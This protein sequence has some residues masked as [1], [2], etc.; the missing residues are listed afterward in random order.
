MKA[1]AQDFGWSAVAAW[2]AVTT[3]GWVAGVIPMVLGINHIWDGNRGDVILMDEQIAGLTTYC[4]VLLLASLGSGLTL[5]IGQWI[6]L[7]HYLRS[8]GRRWVT[9]TIIGSLIGWSAGQFVSI[10]PLV[11]LPQNTPSA[12]VGQG[13]VL[14]L[15]AGASIGIGQSQVLRPLVT[16][17]NQ[18]SL[19]T[20]TYQIMGGSAYWVLRTTFAWGTGGVVFWLVYILLRPPMPLLTEAWPIYK[21]EYLS[22][23]GPATLAGW[24]VGGLVVG[25][26]TALAMKRLLAGAARLPQEVLTPNP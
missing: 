16:A 17:A 2:S 15:V 25:T 1:A 9:V 5:G 11:F 6:V 3:L 4:G 14:I 13:M 10:W 18:W 8:Q 12:W 23:Y 19:E 21:P 24:L 26:M 7:P 20:S 22:D